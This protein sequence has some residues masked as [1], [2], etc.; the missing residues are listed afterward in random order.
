M[1]LVMHPFLR[2]A[3]SFRG[4]LKYDGEEKDEVMQKFAKLASHG[5]EDDIYKI[6]FKV[7][8]KAR[9]DLFSNLV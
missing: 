7:C 9:H 2:L 6:S 1:L 5:A 3:A 8:K 4:I